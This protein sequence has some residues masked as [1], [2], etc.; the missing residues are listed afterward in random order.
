[1]LQHCNMENEINI[2]FCCIPYANL[3]KKLKWK[4]NEH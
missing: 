1:M 4:L 2:R 3:L